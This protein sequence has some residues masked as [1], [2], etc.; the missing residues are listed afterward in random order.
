MPSSLYEYVT[1]SLVSVCKITF[2]RTHNLIN[3][4]IIK[5]NI[6]FPLQAYRLIGLSVGCR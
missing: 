2:K 3:H 6:M 1:T 5:I 4:T